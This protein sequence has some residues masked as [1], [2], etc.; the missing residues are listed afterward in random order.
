[1]IRNSERF[2]AAC[3]PRA[4]ALCLRLRAL[5]ERW[6]PKPECTDNK[7]G[8]GLQI[9]SKRRSDAG[10]PLAYPPLSDFL[11]LGDAA[12]Q[13]ANGFVKPRWRCIDPISKKPS[14]LSLRR[15]A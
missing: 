8:A 2:G 9:D 7:S 10:T 14:P 1:M 11:L 15:A 13:V 3:L 12:R 5:G 4:G 6:R